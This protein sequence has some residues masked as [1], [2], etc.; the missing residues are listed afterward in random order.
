MLHF[1]FERSKYNFIV[2]FII[3]LPSKVKSSFNNFLF[4]VFNS[5]L[6]PDILERVSTKKLLPEKVG[7]RSRRLSFWTG[8]DENAGGKIDFPRAQVPYEDDDSELS[9]DDSAA[10][11]VRNFNQNLRQRQSLLTPELRVP[12][13]P[14]PLAPVDEEDTFVRRLSSVFIPRFEPTPESTFSFNINN[15]NMIMNS[16][17]RGPR[18]SITRFPKPL[19]GDISARSS[20]RQSMS[21][22][23][24][25]F[26]SL[27]STR[28]NRNKPMK[29][30]VQNTPL[31][32]VAPPRGRRVS[33]LGAEEPPVLQLRSD[34]Q[35]D[36]SSAVSSADV[37]LF[38]RQ[39]SAVQEEFETPQ[40]TSPPDI[41]S[42]IFASV[43]FAHIFDT[44]SISTLILHVF[45][46]SCFEL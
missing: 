26:L 10:Q 27:D 19:E 38:G 34:T 6:H 23:A 1:C 14:A 25:E 29:K 45:F 33:I 31:P 7:D 24:R 40:K 3:C 35:S 17:H 4:R 12:V 37:P 5:A 11:R 32:S 22:F 36:D 9:S 39:L 13:A 30:L 16:S 8:D 43:D 28:Q 15:N 20:L 46:A 41:T 2:S 44:F 42:D 18:Q 21:N